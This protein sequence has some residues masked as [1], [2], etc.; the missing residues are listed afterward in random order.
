VIQ[1]LEQAAGV[2]SEVSG[3]AVNCHDRPYGKVMV[4]VPI[5]STSSPP[6]LVTVS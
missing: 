3:A 4:V 6:V 2:Q 1:R 5:G